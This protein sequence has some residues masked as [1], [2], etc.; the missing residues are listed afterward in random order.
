MKDST[1]G[2]SDDGEEACLLTLLTGKAVSPHLGTG[3]SLR[4]RKNLV[5]TEADKKA[6]WARPGQTKAGPSNPKTLASTSLA[7]YHHGVIVD[8]IIYAMLQCH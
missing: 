6:A 2:T 4:R 5:A 7:T 1:F 8:K 3:V